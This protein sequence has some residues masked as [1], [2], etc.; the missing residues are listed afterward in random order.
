MSE[1]IELIVFSFSHFVQCKALKTENLSVNRSFML[2]Q[3]KKP[4]K[5]KKTITPPPPNFLEKIEQ[6]YTCRM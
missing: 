3:K 4:I 2:I 6:G 1:K 5:E